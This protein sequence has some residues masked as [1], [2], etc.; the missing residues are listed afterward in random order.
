MWGGGKFLQRG[1]GLKF[2]LLSGQIP[3]TLTVVSS[4]LGTILIKEILV[5][6]WK[7]GLFM[8]KKIGR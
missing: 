1:L 3:R 2:N 5:I 4:E 8:L 7:P 6:S